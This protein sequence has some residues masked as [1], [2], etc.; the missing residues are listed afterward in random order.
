LA[1][2]EVDS[3]SKRFG[4]LVVLDG[5]SLQVEE[6]ELL[7]IIGPN[8]AGKTTLLN[9]ISGLLAPDGG[10]ILFA[11]RDITELPPHR[12]ARLGIARTFQVPRPFRSLTV[13]QNVAL[14]A[15][16]GMKRLGM[17]EAVEEAGRLLS[18]VGLGDKASLLP[19]SLSV[20]ELRKLELCKALAQ[21]SR[22]LLLDEVSPGLTSQELAGFMELIRDVNR[23]GVTVLIVE[24]DMKVVLGL[25]RRVVAIH[26]G[27]IIAQGRPEE[28]TADGLVR[29][30]YLGE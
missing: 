10:R 3:V 25:C 4:G 28:V 11:G 13:L 21:G 17:A 15:L 7:G 30:A 12:R 6:G 2:L 20:V 22:L 29:R 27:R 26:E 14:S 18:L 19:S 16:S 5:V 8:G 9:I 1:V 24:H 23:A